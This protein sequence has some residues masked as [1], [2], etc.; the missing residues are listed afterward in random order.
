MVSGTDV[1]E[2]K[3]IVAQAKERLL[4]TAEGSKELDISRWRN[5]AEV[6]FLQFR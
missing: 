6:S 3:E 5:C 4:E 2:N 1:Q